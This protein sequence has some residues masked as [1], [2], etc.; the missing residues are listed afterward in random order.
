MTR[1]I[2]ILGAGGHGRVI[3]DCAEALGWR[4]IDFFDDVLAGSVSGV[5]RVVGAEGDLRERVTDYDAVV[6]G[7]G[8][9]R[10]RLRLHRE[11][12]AQGAPLAS[13]IH[14]AATVS[15]HARIG[16]G[17]VVFAGAVV[18]IGAQ[19]GDACIIN[20]GAGVDHDCRLADGVHISPCAHLGGG[21]SVGECSWVGIGASIRH[22]VAI[23][24]DVRVGAGAAVVS[25]VP[26]DSVVVGVPA[27][28]LERSSNA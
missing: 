6:V 15:P 7:I 9:N 25:A 12:V 11:F 20:T 4:R 24:G 13:L 1:A 5:W 19:T 27:R 18:S 3:A 14:P 26:D 22:G 23:G 28:P 16:A 8:D 10:V 17:T 21:V 2:A